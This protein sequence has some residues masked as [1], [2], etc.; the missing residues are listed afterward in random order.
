MAGVYQCVQLNRLVLRIL[1]L[2]SS[3]RNYRLV[4]RLQL[5]V[6]GGEASLSSTHSHHPHFNFKDI[7]YLNHLEKCVGVISY[8]IPIYSISIL[9]FVWLSHIS[10]QDAIIFDLL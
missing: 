3:Q 2:S 8:R 1:Y 7:A 6:L 10:L 5:F 9:P 4:D